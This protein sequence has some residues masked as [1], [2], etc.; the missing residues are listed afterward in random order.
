M[1]AGAGVARRSPDINKEIIAKH[2]TKLRH[3]LVLA[4]G[5]VGASA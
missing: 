2:L 4:R 1:H 5:M 3:E